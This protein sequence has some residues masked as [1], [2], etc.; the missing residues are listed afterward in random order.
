MPIQYGYLK[1]NK[2]IFVLFQF[3]EVGKYFFP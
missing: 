2:N 1:K 3:Y